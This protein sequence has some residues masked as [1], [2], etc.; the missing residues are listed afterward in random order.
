MYSFFYHIFEHFD[1]TNCRFAQNRNATSQH[2]YQYNM[3]I[4]SAPEHPKKRSSLT[5]FAR[6]GLLESISYLKTNSTKHKG[7]YQIITTDAKRIAVADWD[8]FCSQSHT[9]VSQGTQN[10]TAHGKK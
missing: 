10:R 8:I 6:S 7:N 3:K 1:V 2:R 9:R 4:N 5:C